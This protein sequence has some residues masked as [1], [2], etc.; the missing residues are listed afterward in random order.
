[1]IWTKRV[2]AFRS[3]V[4]EGHWTSCTTCR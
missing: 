2:C 3:D 1:M 4:Q